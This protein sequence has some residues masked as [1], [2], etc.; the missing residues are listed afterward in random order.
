MTRFFLFGLLVLIAIMLPGCATEIRDPKSGVVVFKTYGDSKQLA[1]NKRGD[2]YSLEAI[3]LKHSPVIR[4]V[5]SVVGT[6]TAGALPIVG[7][8]VRP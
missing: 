7:A 1:F 2:D 5:G 4:A 8:I 3:D 6:A